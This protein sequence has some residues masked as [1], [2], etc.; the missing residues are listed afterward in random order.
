MRTAL[1]WERERNEIN[2]GNMWRSLSS[3]IRVQL[4]GLLTRDREFS[5]TADTTNKR[6]GATE[7]NKCRYCKEEGLV[8]S[9]INADYSCEYCGEWQNA[10]LNT[11]WYVAGY[12][13]EAS[14]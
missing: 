1:E 11:A 4:P 6:E 10:I 8:L 2:T 12:K 9:T 3:N 7:M 5:R 14:V 13:E